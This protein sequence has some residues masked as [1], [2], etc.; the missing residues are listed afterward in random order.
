MFQANPS[1]EKK[2]CSRKKFDHPIRSW[3]LAQRQDDSRNKIP[4][5][6]GQC[7]SSQ[8]EKWKIESLCIFQRS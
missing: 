8:V 1:E 6:G 7:G 5:M 2:V 3:K 4:K